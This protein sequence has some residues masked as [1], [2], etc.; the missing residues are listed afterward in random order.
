[1][2]PPTVGK[3]NHQAKR[4]R[5]MSKVTPFLMFNDQLESALE[6]YKGLFSDFE[7]KQVHRAGKDGPIQSAEFVLGGQSFKAFNGGPHFSFS[8]GV[9]LY[10]DCEG[11]REVDEYWSRIERAG[12]TPTQCGWINDPFGLSWQVIPR[13]LVELT[14]DRDPKRV[15][16]V[17]DAMLKMTRLD[18]AALEEAYEGARPAA[19]D[20]HHN[21]AAT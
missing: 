11:Q 19:A 17:V 13:R 3:T 9:S 8:E 21:D 14:S 16:A 5:S 18:V 10:I 2:E 6:F 12:G 1:M 20:R 15:K 4:K 7:I